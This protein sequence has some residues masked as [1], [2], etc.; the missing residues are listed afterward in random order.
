M[1]KICEKLQ[2]LNVKCSLKF[3][4]ANSGIPSAILDGIKD[5]SFTELYTILGD[6]IFFGNN[7]IKDVLSV[8]EKNLILTK[9]VRNPSHFGI[10][11]SSKEKI[12]I[13]EKPKTFIGNEAVTGF[14][15]FDNNINKYLERAVPSKR[16]E[17]EIADVLNAITIENENFLKQI[18]L[19]R[20]T[21]WLDAGTFE[22]LNNSCSLVSQIIQ[23][24]GQDFG[25]IEEAALEGNYISKKNLKKLIQNYPNNDYK[26]Y[27]E[28]LLDVKNIG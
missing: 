10:L 4:G 19:N 9:E 22:N 23:R 1:N 24:Q 7:F 21:L 6:N 5:E 12:E 18:K 20:A 27:I 28:H 8:N 11:N 3:Q 15:K 13:I 17:T 16:G 25:C 2:F 26:N 14:Y